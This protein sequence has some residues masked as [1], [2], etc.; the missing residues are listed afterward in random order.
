MFHEYYDLLKGTEVDVKKP[1]RVETKS[2]LKLAMQYF[3]C[4]YRERIKLILTALGEEDCDKTLYV[5]HHC[6]EDARMLHMSFEELE[7]SVEYVLGI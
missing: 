7:E 6:I 1:A 3:V 5:I 2:D 4:K